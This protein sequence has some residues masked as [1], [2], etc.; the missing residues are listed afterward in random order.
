[1]SCLFISLGKLLDQ[2]HT[3]CNYT[4]GNLARLDPL[5]TASAEPRCVHPHDTL[6]CHADVV[7]GRGKRVA[8]ARTGSRGQLST[9]RRGPAGVMGSAISSSFDD[10]NPAM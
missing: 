3:I 6:D 7:D 1:M 8:D 4:Q 5:V 10:D 2:P 9:N